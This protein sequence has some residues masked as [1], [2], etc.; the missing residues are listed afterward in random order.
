[1]E[2]SWLATRGLNF[3][4]IETNGIIFRFHG[5]K[6]IMYWPPLCL[7]DGGSPGLQFELSRV[8]RLRSRPKKTHELLREVRRHVDPD[9]LVRALSFFDVVKRSFFAANWPR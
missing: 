4:M 7:V 8:E 9:H 3:L 2:K 6:L 5:K 1:M